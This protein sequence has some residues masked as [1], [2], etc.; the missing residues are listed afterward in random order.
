MKIEDQHQNQAGRP[1]SDKAR[2]SILNSVLMLIDKESPKDITIKLIAEKANVGRQTIYRWWN[3]RGEIILEALLE[4]SASKI[5]N[6][7]TTDTEKNVTS[8]VKDTVSQANVVKKALAV[9][10]TDAQLEDEFMDKF[11]LEFIKVRREAF[12]DIFTADERYRNMNKADRTFLCDLF[13]GPLWYRVL[14]RHAP[15]NNQFS[16]QLSDLIVTWLK[17]QYG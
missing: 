13:F 3:N 11:R 7:N 1:R 5:I 6:I 16:E 9:I 8:F 10:M 17:N 4:L 12:L 14:I 15:L 2:A